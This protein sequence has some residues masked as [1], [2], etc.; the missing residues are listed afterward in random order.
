MSVIPG[1]ML[2]DDEKISVPMM[3]IALFG[4]TLAFLMSLSWA[5]FLSDS[6]EAVHRASGQKIPLSVSRLFSAIIV[7]GVATSLFTAL[8][9]WERKVAKER[10]LK[11]EK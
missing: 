4:S 8:Y 3:L 9:A 7:T 5:S 11:A 6:V 2:D 10:D 1:Q